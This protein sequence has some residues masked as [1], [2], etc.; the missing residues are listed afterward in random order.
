MVT[1][2]EAAVL[3]RA[4]VRSIYARVE[5]GGIHFVELSDGLLLIGADSLSQRGR[6]DGLKN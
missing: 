3:A 4:T 2:E 1:P 5:A 6:F